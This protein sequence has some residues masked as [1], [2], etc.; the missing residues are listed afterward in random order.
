MH[1]LT[2]EA[3]HWLPP[4]NGHVDEDRTLPGVIQGEAT[5][6]LKAPATSLPVAASDEQLLAWVRAVARQ[7]E[8]AFSELYRATVG[9]VYGVALRF[10]RS[11]ESAEEVTEDVFVQVWRTAASFDANRGRVLTWLLTIARS[12]ALDYLRRDEPAE[13]HED[14]D[15]LRGDQ[16]DDTPGPQDLL[17][18][19]Q[20]HQALHRALGVL[21]PVQRQLLGLAFF[22]GLTHQ[23]IAEHAQLPLG[24]VKTHVRR[25]LDMLR[26]H[27]TSSGSF[28]S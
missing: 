27:L 7:D 9:R 6:T 10:V 1:I 3:N 28:P 8:Q 11:R 19:T 24:T 14:P 2:L 22:R 13:P 26:E 18:L 16:Q 25:G 5:D 4:M 23:E 17:Q 15:S 21:S 12:R 20:S